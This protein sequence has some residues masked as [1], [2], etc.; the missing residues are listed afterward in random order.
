MAR[1]PVMSA[2]D[3]KWEAE[4]DARTLAEAKVIAADKARLK[5]AAV[6]AKRMADD[7]MKEARAMKQVAKKAPTKTTKKK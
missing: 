4:S 6:A 5:A 7:K 2:Q 1:Q 3:K